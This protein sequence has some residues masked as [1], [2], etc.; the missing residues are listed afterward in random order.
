M[1]KMYV[2]YSKLKLFDQ[3]QAAYAYKYI[4]ERPEAKNEALL[5]GKA[6]HEAVAS[7]IG[8]MDTGM[9]AVSAAVKYGIADKI[10]CIAELTDQPIVHEMPPGNVE[11]P[12]S[13]PLNDDGSIIFEGVIDYWR[14]LDNDAVHLLDWKT[15]R[16]KYHPLDN[17]QLGLYAWALQELNGAAEIYAELVFLR[18]DDM[19]NVT[20]HN[21]SDDEGISLAKL[22]ATEVALLIRETTAVWDDSEKVDPLKIFTTRCGSHCLHCGFA[23]DCVHGEL[24]DWLNVKNRDNAA[25]AAI[26]L[27]RLEAA[28]A[29]LKAMLKDYVSKNGSL[30]VDGRHFDFSTS[31]SWSFSPES[32]KL[33]SDC[34]KE[35]NID[36]LDYATVSAAGIKKLALSDAELAQFGQPKSTKTF[37]HI[38]D[39]ASLCSN[40]QQTDKSTHIISETLE[41]RI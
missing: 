17:D 7:I 11:Y 14:S 31:T 1:S 28:L 20:W 40:V 26:E 9:A 39:I 35:R 19:R 25:I 34:L 2:S 4:F 41:E 16:N 22:W 32:I 30:S 24:F 18:H 23:H 38:A 10:D 12:F 5:I 21:Y 13:L 27:L 29:N 15:N 36:L 33:L 6:V 3:C 37:R 8:G